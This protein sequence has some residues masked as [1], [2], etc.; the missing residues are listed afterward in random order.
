MSVAVVI[1]WG[2][3]LVLFAVSF[4]IRRQ[5][6]VRRG[7]A[8]RAARSVQP[9][10]TNTPKP[11]EVL[12]WV[13]VDGSARELTEADKK[14]VDTEFSPFDGARPYIK[15]HY[16]Q[17]NGWGE[18]SGYLHRKEVPDGVLVNPAPPASPLQQPQAM[19]GSILELIQNHRLD[20]VDKIRFKLPP[21]PN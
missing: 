18:L 4:W 7:S 8:A 12:I 14:Y 17:R 10:A 2:L 5:R 20:D 1:G 16:Q 19:A 15:S 13:N 9:S 21:S 11:S 6:R 3:A